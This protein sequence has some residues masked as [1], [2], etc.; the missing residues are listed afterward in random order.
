MRSALKDLAK[1]LLKGINLKQFGF[2]LLAGFIFLMLSKLSE[3]TVE[4]VKFNIE[5][6]DIPKDIQLRHDSTFIFNTR[7]KST[8]FNFFSLT[9]KN[10]DPI[11]L[12]IK[13]DLIKI[14]DSSYLWS[15]GPGF[16][17]LRDKLPESFQIVE[18][19]LDTLYFKYDQLD[20]KQVPIRID[21]KLSFALG[22]DMLG[23]IESSKDSVIVI[24]P[25]HS[26]DSISKISTEFFSFQD[27]KADFSSSVA[28]LNPNQQ[29]VTLEFNSVELSGHIR[30][31]TEGEVSVKVQL[32]NVPPDVTINFFPKEVSVVYYVDLDRFSSITEESFEV[33]CDFQD[34]KKTGEFYLDPELKVQS[35]FVKSARIK[36]NRIDFI[37]L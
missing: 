8:G 36:A 13:D 34:Y 1:R 26:I 7:I 17:N 33:F 16:K 32:L 27:L 4:D 29:E 6:T 11:V 2:F 25:K 22:F 24:G 20:S 3:S 30:R 35:E 14:N 10:P 31:F 15:H 28:L 18:T 19:K 23:E 37:F 21:S 9:F 12:S 5:I